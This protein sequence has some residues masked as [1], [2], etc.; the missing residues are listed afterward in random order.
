M[1]FFLLHTYLL[2]FAITANAQTRNLDYYQKQAQNNSPLI[3][4]AKNKN[5]LL[6]LD[7]QNVKAVLS[8]PA[9]SL[10]G[11]LLFAPIIAHDNNKN[12]FQWITETA[13][14]YTGYDLGY[15][16]GGQYQATVSL[17]QPLFT[18]E[19]YKAYSKQADIQTQLN[20]NEIELTKHELEMLVNRQYF[21]C[22]LAKKQ[23][24]ISKSLSDELDNQLQIT[25]KLVEHAL[26]KQ[27]DLMLMKIEIENYKSEYEKYLSEYTENLQDLNLIC[28]INNSDSTDI[29]DVTILAKPDAISDSHF[30]DTF[31]LD[32]LSVLAK[33]SVFDRQYRPQVNLVAD[34]GMNAVYLPSFDRFGFAVGINFTWTVFDGN[35]KDIQHKKSLI[36]LQNI[37]YQ[38]QNFTTTQN[39]N[40]QKYLTKIQAAET[41]IN[42][43]K[44][45]LAAYEKL[46]KLY[47][48]ELSNAQISITDF[49]N[50]IRDISEKKQEK[51]RLEIQ[52][53]LL[54]NS[55]NYWNY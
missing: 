53:Q 17:K 49:N 5:K 1:K 40:K 22:L 15:S 11:N 9:V 36:E 12:Q 39:I 33:Q 26:Y 27:I 50:I 35:Q 45:Q 38:K 8:K 24:Q 30:S 54:I 48:L 41:Q 21:L 23:A 4:S 46:I 44:N 52:K 2:L 55:Y 20:I 25:E 51:L 28:G 37:E 7:I 13:D 16:D 42:I 3:K 10:K 6:Q 19:T 32:S 34:A 14:S 29:E 47:Q 31:R 18:A 43:I